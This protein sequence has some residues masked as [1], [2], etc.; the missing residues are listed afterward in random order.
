MFFKE[1]LKTMKTTGAVASSWRFL[2]NKMANGV[3]FENT[4][5]IVEFG[6]GLGVL[7]KKLL[8]KMNNNAKLISYEINE[9][10]Y[11]RIKDIKDDRLTLLNEDVM[12]FDT[13]LDNKNIQSVDYVLSGLPLAIFS[14]EFVN[15]LMT[16]VYEKLKPG[17][18]YIQ[19]QYST[20]SLKTLKSHF[21]NVNMKLAVI[22]IPPA[23]IYYCEKKA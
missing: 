13:F 11:D 22:N 15:G 4:E 8:K 21:D 18:K 23:V 20:T 3:D 17:G 16:K 6:A 14:K 1:A 7:T 9:N 5:T 12:T 10:F 2:V 19:F